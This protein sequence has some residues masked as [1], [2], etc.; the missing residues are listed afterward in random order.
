[1]R[2]VAKDGRPGCP[3]TVWDGPYSTRCGAGAS[4]GKCAHHGKF[5]SPV[6]PELAR[7]LDR[8]AHMRNQVELAREALEDE[9]EGDFT[10]A[11]L[12]LKDQADALAALV[13]SW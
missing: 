6:P 10:R 7:T 3:V 11:I 1:M 9:R 5:A 13:A 8:L 12:R 4:V 2:Y